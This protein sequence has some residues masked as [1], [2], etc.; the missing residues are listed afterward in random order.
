[1]NHDNNRSRHGDWLIFRSTEATRPTTL[2]P[3]NVPVPLEPLGDSPSH[4]ERLHCDARR[5]LST[6]VG[7]TAL[8]LSGLFSVRAAAADGAAQ[9]ESPSAIA[10]HPN[11]AL[12]ASSAVASP[13]QAQDERQALVAARLRL[14]DES[15]SAAAHYRL[16]VLAARQAE[17]PE[18]IDHLR[19]SLMLEPDDA[20]AAN[21]LAWILAVCPSGDFRDGGQAL[22]LATQLCERTDR[23]NSTLL[24]TL[25]A[26]QAEQGRF[27]DAIRTAEDAIRQARLAKRSAEA[28]QILARLELYRQ[29]Q[30]YRP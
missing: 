2:G 28:R 27:D 6:S 10:L 25:S 14:A 4:R 17:W 5:W 16:A 30:A 15:K 13:R 26:A 3:K 20:A 9:T 8:A 29:G 7:L 22:T 11:D 23:Q 24:D 1:M 21:V 18:A 19:R 12:L